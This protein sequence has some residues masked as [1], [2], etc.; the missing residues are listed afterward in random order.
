MRAT[1]LLALAALAGLASCTARPLL[2]FDPS[3]G[4]LAR[5]AAADLHCSEPLEIR[6]LTLLTRVATGCDHQAVYAYDWMRDQW[7]WDHG[8]GKGQDRAPGPGASE[9]TD[10]DEFRGPMR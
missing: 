6:R 4:E 9:R 10:A 1:L 2:I 3:I 7:V 8:E 5:T